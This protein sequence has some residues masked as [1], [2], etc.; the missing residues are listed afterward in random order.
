MSNGRDGFDA[1]GVVIDWIDACKQHR[2]DDLIDLYDAGATVECCEGGSFHGR[3]EME[4]YWKPRLARAIAGAFEID[5][6]TPEKN[7]V[8]LDYRGYDGLPVRTYFRF[9]NRGKI[10]LTACVPIRAAA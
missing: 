1:L 4:A 6:L 2:L 9:T 7:G 5:V 10:I 3:S 8:L